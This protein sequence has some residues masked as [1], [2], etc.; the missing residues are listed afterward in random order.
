MG[1]NKRSMTSFLVGVLQTDEDDLF[2][3]TNPVY[4][5][6]DC[7]LGIRD[8]SEMCSVPVFESDLVPGSIMG[9]FITQPLHSE[10]LVAL[11]E[12]VEEVWGW[13]ECRVVLV[14]RRSEPAGWPSNHVHECCLRG[15]VNESCC[16]AATSVSS[17]R[18]EVE[19]I[20]ILAVRHPA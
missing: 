3:R 20:S 16:S 9:A 13:T 12:L 10:I 2:L 19:M 1:F 6:S 18:S 5:F 7:V 8:L 14:D 11:F 17:R 15:N 4:E